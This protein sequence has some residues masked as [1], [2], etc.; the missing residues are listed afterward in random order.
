MAALSAVLWF[1][2]E[3]EAAM[4]FYAQLFGG[5]TSPILLNGTQV[6]GIELRAGGMNIMAL[7][8]PSATMPLGGSILALVA[9]QPELDRL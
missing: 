7:N 2:G 5:Q 9:D 3:A 8:V 6:A 1:D 4:A